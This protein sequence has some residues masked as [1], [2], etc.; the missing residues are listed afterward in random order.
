MTQ[1]VTQNDPSNPKVYEK[2]E[3][4]HPNCQNDTGDQSVTQNQTGF[5]WY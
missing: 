5:C 4:I 2:F 1:E 3:E